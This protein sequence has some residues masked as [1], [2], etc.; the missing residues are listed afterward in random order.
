[1]SFRN[2]LLIGD[3]RQVLQGIEPS[4]IDMVLTSPPYFRLRDY[5]VPGQIGLEAAIE[6][7]VDQVAGVMAE[8]R[9]VLVPTGTLWLNL[10]D[11]FATH[12]REGAP[13]KSLLLGPERL[14]LRLIA[15][16]WVLRNKIVWHKA[17]PMPSSVAD[18]LACTW[19]VIYVFA[20]QPCYFFDLDAVRVPHTSR[21]SPPVDRDH[22]RA[23]EPW[24]GPN[25]SSTAGIT[26]LK[27]Q[28][29][30]GHPLGKNLGD[31]WRIASSNFRGGHHATFPVALAERAIRAGAPEARCRRCRAPWRRSLLRT[32]IGTAQRAPLASTCSCPRTREAAVV[33][34]PFFGAGTTALA[35]ARLGRD[36]LGVELNPAYGHLAR[37]RIHDARA[38]P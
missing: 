6:A 20:T 38:G 12:P 14:A 7:W 23:R 9:R 19:E 34:D 8:V 17:N 31:V 5:G 32:A 2:R 22:T 11:S 30:V 13:R 18:R 35:A 4:T 26:K 24:R 15:D 37:R 21:L 10:G 33:L 16:G 27:Q 36:W 28:G 1:M 29:L 25:S 3:A